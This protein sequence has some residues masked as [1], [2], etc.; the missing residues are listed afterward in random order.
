MIRFLALSLIALPLA[1]ASAQDVPKP[2]TDAAYNDIP[3][4]FRFAIVCD[5]TGGNRAGVFP[6]ALHKAALLEPEFVMSVG[7]FIEGYDED[8]PAIDREWDG[9][10]SEIEANLPVRFYFVP[11]NHD[12]HWKEK[13]GLVSQEKWIERFGRSYYHFVYK[14]VLFLCL[15]TEDPPPSSVSAE[16]CAYFK[17]ALEENAGVA[18]TCIFMHKPLW[19]DANAKGW[20]EFEALL[21]GRPYTVFAGHRHNYAKH[22]HD[23]RN[24]YVLA[25]SGGGNAL[26]GEAFGEFDQIV[27]VTMTPEG[28]RL[29]NLLL[30]GIRDDAPTTK[31][32]VAFAEALAQAGVVRVEPLTAALDSYKGGSARLRFKNPLSVPIRIAADIAPNH[33][34]NAAP[35]RVEVEIP[36]HGDSSAELQVRVDAPI[37]AAALHPLPLEWRAEALTQSGPPV[38]VDGRMGI[39][40]ATPAVC[41]L[42]TEPIN[43]DGSLS[44]W[45]ALPWQCYEAAEISGTHYLWSGPGDASFRFSVQDD[46]A[47]LHMGVQVQDDIITLNPGRESWKQD[48]LRIYIDARDLPPAD[49]ARPSK[50]FEDF[51]LVALSPGDG[52]TLYS[53][54]KLPQG[55]NAVCGNIPGG[56][57]LEVSIPSKYLDGIAGDTWKSVRINVCLTDVDGGPLDPRTHLWWQP[58][59][60]RP[61]DNPESGCFQRV[62]KNSSKS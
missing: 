31:Q 50:E 41:T 2:W 18:W 3:G 58:E 22:E 27:W 30:D 21:E 49:R 52:Q 11:G 51:L 61:N 13:T 9:I 38:S 62:P 32:S 19:D 39:C 44:E 26:R 28:P 10:M 25:T 47:N 53:P 60:G 14:N 37:K 55:L 1:A 54:E 40:I 48:G 35:S 24:Y 8:G 59:W 45:P 56:Y 16:Q 34:M 15:N 20:P 43:V 4:S 23:K 36:P 57:S 6:D 42:P 12:I 29:S 46:G 7:D 33:L 5:R 17:T